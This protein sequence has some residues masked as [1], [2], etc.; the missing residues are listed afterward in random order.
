MKSRIGGNLLNAFCYLLAF[1][2]IQFVM[3]LVGGTIW[4]MVKGE[5]FRTALE[6]AANGSLANDG[7]AMAVIT[8][9]ASVVTIIVFML[10]RWSPF[11]RTYLRSRPWGVLAWVFIL[12]FGT[13]I[14]SEWLLEQ[15]NVEIIN[16]IKILLITY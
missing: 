11:S 16:Q 2:I 4:L 7:T 15:L 3:T 9:A 13:V 14:P 6:Q 8:A 10:F 5:E 12:T 1:L